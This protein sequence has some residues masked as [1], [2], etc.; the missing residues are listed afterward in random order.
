MT[1]YIPPVTDMQFA[2]HDVLK[3]SQSGLPGHEDLDR[4]F[5][6][7]VLDAAGKLAAEVLAPLNAVGDRQGCRLEIGVVRTPDGFDRAF[8]AMK[9]GGWTA[10]DCDPDY[11]GQGMPYVMGVAT[12]EMFVSG[13]PICR[14][15]SAATGPAP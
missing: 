9:E 14:K 7:A 12:G 5:T 13:R 6:E 3:L 2:L 11:G 8:Q 10:L 15:W 4:D 1:I